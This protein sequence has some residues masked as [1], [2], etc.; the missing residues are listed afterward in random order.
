MCEIGSEWFARFLDQRDLAML[1]PFA[2]SN[3]E[4]ATP[5]SYLHVGDLEGGN[6]GDP[7][8]RLAEQRCQCQCQ[9]VIATSRCFCRPSDCIPF[10]FG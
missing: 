3:N 1:E 7:W 6:L 8:T 10:G 5:G 9:S 4:Q 2:T